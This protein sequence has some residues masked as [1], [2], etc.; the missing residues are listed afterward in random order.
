MTE[1]DARG[2]RKESEVGREWDRSEKGGRKRT[3]EVSE[4]VTY[5]E[6]EANEETEAR[7]KLTQ[8]RRGRKGRRKGG[9][10]RCAKS[11]ESVGIV[12]GENKG[13]GK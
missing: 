11:K 10:G 9:E 6:G 1:I 5:R 7:K 2:E 12:K 4:N 13:E 8:R 3:R